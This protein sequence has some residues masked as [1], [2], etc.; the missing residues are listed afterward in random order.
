MNISTGAVGGLYGPGRPTDPPGAG[1]ALAPGPR[2]P[3]A[4][5][6]P[7]PD[8]PR[9]PPE[10]ATLG[11]APGGVL[12]RNALWNGGAYLVHALVLLV[13]SPLVVALLGPEAFGVWVLINA[14]TG[15]LG[16][17]DFG[18]RPAIVHF[19]ARHHAC[20]DP[21]AVN[22][23]VSSALVTLGAGAGLVILAC[24][25]LALGLH[26]WFDL[27]AG[28]AREAVAALLV[29]GLGL[30]VMLVLNAYSAVLIGRQRYDLTCRVDLFVT[31][32]R[33]AA[34]VAV[35]WLEG[36]LLAL[37]LVN[38]AAGLTEMGW[39]TR[40]AFREAPELRA[41]PHLADRAAVRDLLRY[42]GYN[43]LVAA[44]LHLVY[45]SDEVVIAAVLTLGEVTLYERAAVLAASVRM[46]CWATG[47]VLMPELGA[48]DARGQGER[49][50]A[51]LVTGGRNVLLLAGPAVAFLV[52]LGGAFLETWMHGEAAY[53][54]HSG[55]VLAVL[56]LGLLAPVASAPL[57]AA[58]QGTNQMRSLARFAGAE[59]VANLA[60]SLAL[61]PS[62][63]ILG[64]ALGTA[65]PGFL[66]HAV[67]MPAVLCRRYGLPLSRYLAGVWLE[68]LA[69]G[70]AVAL[71][72]LWLSDP[73]GAH[74]W[75][76]LAGWALVATLPFA[77][78][79]ARHR[80]RRRAPA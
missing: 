58:Q 10:P 52:V 3:S 24:G 19:V 32:G 68:P 14:L 2:R 80:P 18:I 71:A 56:A 75:A 25:T 53:R 42:G 12:A 79:L 23:Y 28:V 5:P 15:Y 40:L 30:A 17:A 55:P 46:L 51:L 6:A 13:L 76:G 59:G 48:L 21:A 57:V 16:V 22:R 34:I 62:L 39:K 77:L 7:P 27:P 33:S 26:A 45:Q 61:A 65:I 31:L 38:V 35:L 64:V 69:L 54:V 70:G 9:L 47:R 44:A 78:A 1:T 8:S 4:M 67:W 29:S 66:V 43:L 60:V 11:P 63:G 36:G 74:G 49:I 73:R 37:A 20:G 72:L 41:R 50:R